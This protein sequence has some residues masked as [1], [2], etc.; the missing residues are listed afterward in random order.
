MLLYKV[1]LGFSY[2]TY[3]EQVTVMIHEAAAIKH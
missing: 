2:Y 3:E 1:V